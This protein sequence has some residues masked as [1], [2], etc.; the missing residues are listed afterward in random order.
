[1]GALVAV[2]AV[3]LLV[4]F[5]AGWLVFGLCWTLAGVVMLRDPRIGRRLQAF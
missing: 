5:V 3:G 2:A 1:V 4:P